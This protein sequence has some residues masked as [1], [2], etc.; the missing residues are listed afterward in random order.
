MAIELKQKKYTESSKWI[1]ILLCV[2]I[3]MIA[4][5][6]AGYFVLG[7][8]TNQAK[9]DISDLNTNIQDNS[10]LETEIR[11]YQQKINDFSKILSGRRNM[12]MF[13][14][15][16]ESLCHPSVWVQNLESNNLDNQISF[17]GKTESFISLGQQYLIL[18]SSPAIDLVNLSKIEINE[19]NGGVDFSFDL[20][21][22]DK[23]FELIDESSEDVSTT[24]EEISEGN[25]T[26]TEEIN[27]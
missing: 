10:G 12:L 14:S 4:L 21:F 23:V 9:K 20:I 1:N 5:G 27:E 2:S 25:S 16:F 3:G 7:S 22:N 15:F 6:L 13:F 18:K 26:T 8:L 17:S 11:N 24:T 19:E